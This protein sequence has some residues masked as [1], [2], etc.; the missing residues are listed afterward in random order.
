MYVSERLEEICI[1]ILKKEKQKPGVLERSD[2]VNVER[3]RFTF[4]KL[5]VRRRSN[6][7]WEDF[8]YK[9]K[10]RKKKKKKKREAQRRRNGRNR[11]DKL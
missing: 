11:H 4:V 9:Y 6:N 7:R 3:N 5:V 8:Y 1:N 2:L 10:K